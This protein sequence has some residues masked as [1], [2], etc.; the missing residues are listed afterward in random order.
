MKYSYIIIDDEIQSALNT[1]AVF[2]EFENY[3]LVGIALNQK[4]ALLLVALHKPDIIVLE[5]NPSDQNS[6]LS[7]RIIHE[8]QRHA[9]ANPQVIV[10]TK[11]TKLAYEAL[12]SNVL[13]YIKK[14]LD[15][16]ELQKSLLRFEEVVQNRN[17]VICVKSYGDY[18]FVE[19]DEIVYL[20]ADN[21][22]T[23]MYTNS[24]TV[25]I[26]F[27]S[28]KHFESTLPAQF[29]R[30]HKS[31]IINMNYIARIQMS[32]NTCYLKNSKTQLPFSQTYRKNVIRIINHF[33]RKED[34]HI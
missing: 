34:R 27:K 22:S 5:I 10:H 12:K 1:Q 25:V 13:D 29:V 3:N 18:R 17:T 31:Y 33:A 9:K 8:I 21:N 23:D 20:K 2:E 26:A 14:P 16:F 4:E 11:D 24:G 15:A 30:I 7:L 28:M 32:N 19:A 6:G